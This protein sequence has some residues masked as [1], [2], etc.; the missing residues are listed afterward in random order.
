MERFRSLITFPQI[1]TSGRAI[2]HFEATW[3]CFIDRLVRR[4]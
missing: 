4:A 2:N 3:L 1:T